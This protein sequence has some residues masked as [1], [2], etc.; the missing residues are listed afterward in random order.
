M[1]ASLKLNVFVLCVFYL[2]TESYMCPANCINNITGHVPKEKRLGVPWTTTLLPERKLAIFLSVTPKSRFLPFNSGVDNF[3]LLY[4]K[5]LIAIFSFFF[6]LN[7]ILF[8]LLYFF[9]FFCFRVSSFFFSHCGHFY[10]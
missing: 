5:I 2:L 7:L 3:F 8:L 10:P 6:S 9:F 4:Q 1:S